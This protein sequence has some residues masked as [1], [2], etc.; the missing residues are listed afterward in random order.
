MRPNLT[1][2]LLALLL[3]PAAA[4]DVLYLGSS[5]GVVR[6]G[7]PRT[8]DYSFLA[9]C[10]GPIHSLALDG[11]D[12]FIGDVSGAIYHY[13]GSSGFVDYSFTSSNDATALL[14]DGGELL[15]GGSDSTVLRVDKQDGSLLATLDTTVPVGAL[16]LVDGLLYV[17]S[18]FGV[19]VRGDPATGPFSFWGTCGGAVQSMTH[20]STHVL[21]G[22][23]SG[24]LYRLDRATQAVTQSFALQNEATAMVLHVGD[25]LTGGS[26]GSVSRVHRVSGAV[27]DGHATA[28]SVDAL[29]LAVDAGPGTGYCY[30]AEGACPCGN[31]DGLAGCASSE[32]VGAVLTGTGSASVAQDDLVLLVDN[33]PPQ[34]FGR[35]YMGASAPQNPFGDGLFCAG[36]GGYGVRRFPVFDSGALGT[37]SLETVAAWAQANFPPTSQVLPGLTWNFQV[38][39]RDPQGPCG[40]TINTSSAYAVTFQP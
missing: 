2:P 39:Y 38:W 40:G 34:K 17:G 15:I 19:V 11:E 35:F 1:T 23:T 21:L 36:S 30:G 22:T 20:D 29:A 28:F 3:A 5:D 6:A 4:A 12:L 32:E 7:D 16:D 14:V 18:T 8:G 27:K 26:D 9:I 33:L 24:V 31:M 13:D 37:A 25:L 10:G